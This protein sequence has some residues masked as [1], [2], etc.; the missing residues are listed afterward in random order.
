VRE[1]ECDSIPALFQRS[2]KFQAMFSG[3]LNS[4]SSRNGRGE[5][6]GQQHPRQHRQHRDP[7]PQ[8]NNTFG[9]TLQLATYLFPQP[10]NHEALLQVPA[11]LQNRELRQRLPSRP[12]SSRK[13]PGQIHTVAVGRQYLDGRTGGIIERVSLLRGRTERDCQ[14]GEQDEMR[15]WSEA[16]ERDIPTGKCY[17]NGVLSRNNQDGKTREDQGMV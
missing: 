2:R 6:K 4:R 5:R 16:I 17:G 13:G 1:T 3:A 15:R 14:V 11:V 7:H 8:H 10:A 9:F 12:V